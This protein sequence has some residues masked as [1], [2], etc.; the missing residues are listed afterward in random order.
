MAFMKL[1]NDRYTM[2]NVFAFQKGMNLKEKQNEQKQKLNLNYELEHLCCSVCNCFKPTTL[3]LNI[4][5]CYT[6]FKKN[7]EEILRNWDFNKICELNYIN[8][9]VETH[10]EYY[11]FSR[12]N[13]ND[14][15]RYFNLI[16]E[17]SR[18]ISDLK[19]HCKYENGIYRKETNDELYERK[20]NFH[21]K[22]LKQNLIKNKCDECN[23]CKHSTYEYTVYFDDYIDSDDSDDSDDEYN[24][25][26]VEE[27]RICYS[28]FI[29]KKLNHK[30]RKMITKI[31]SNSH[32]SK[33]DIFKTNMKD[34]QLFYNLRNNIVNKTKKLKNII[35]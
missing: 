18:Q 29:D 2:T 32:K 14:I 1:F 31:I 27:F 4:R 30:K 22:K 24:F 5:I 12:E 15:N 3:A 8:S 23:Y 16:K 9:L 17:T 25:K 34:W 10:S 13:N 11:R 21:F 26:K 6:C 20:R 35:K 28:C 33:Y 7:K 19:N